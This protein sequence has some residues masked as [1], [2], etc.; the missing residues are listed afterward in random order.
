MLNDKIA[1]SGRWIV[2]GEKI[3]Y[4]LI[5]D[6]MMIWENKI[7]IHFEDGFMAV[8]EKPA[9]IPTSGNTLRNL[10]NALPYNLK[11]STEEDGLPQPEPVHRLDAATSGLVIVAKTW[12]TLRYLGVK[13]KNKGIQK[14]YFALVSG[15]TENIQKITSPIDGKS[16]I[17]LVDKIITH[18]SSLYGNF[19]LLT[20]IPYTGRTHQIRIHLS[21]INCPILGD[22]MCNQSDTKLVRGLML[23]AYLLEFYHPV[24]LEKI[25]IE[26]SLPKRITKKLRKY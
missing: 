2:G 13:L 8:V 15:N 7:K 17:T 26:S 21:S 4:S 11:L 25:R 24:T 22:K 6:N 16:A 3:D 5:G 12:H 19:S 14:K 10:R 18:T 1:T 9:G 20:A 23:H